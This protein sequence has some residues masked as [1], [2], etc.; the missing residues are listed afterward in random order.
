MSAPI[1]ALGQRV[2]DADNVIRG[3][4]AGAALAEGA[5]G[6]WLDTLAIVRLDSDCSGWVGGKEGAPFVDL[7]LVHPSNLLHE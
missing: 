7:L 5:D 3:V 1:F 4:Y 2:R 6:R